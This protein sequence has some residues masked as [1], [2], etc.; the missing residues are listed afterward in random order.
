M[1]VAAKAIKQKIKG[2][3]N[4]RKITRTMEMVSVSKMKKATFAAL[5]V[6]SYSLAALNI[7]SHI[8]QKT[9]SEHSYFKMRES[10]TELL[11]LVSSNKGLC[12]SY[13]TNLYRK[14]IQYIKAQEAKSIELITIGKQAEKIAKRTGLAIRASFT[15][16]TDTPRIEDAESVLQTVLELYNKNEYGYVGILYTHF[17]KQMNYTPKIRKL[18]PLDTKSIEEIT[19]SEDQVVIAGQRETIFEPNE[20]T[21]L[22]EIVPRLLSAVIFGALCDA[23][24][25]EHSTRMF[26]MKTASD[27]AK[28]I[29]RILTISYNR[30]RQDAVTQELAEIAAGAGAVA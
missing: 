16:I 20:S 18:F 14:L 27:N 1:A 22:E 24:A 11:I 29:Q 26:A 21:V 17:V 23:S 6:R 4:I 30:A 15:D 13:N 12:G 7:L 5:L 3:G 19:N 28:E 25:S 9:N 2:V 8:S 10:K